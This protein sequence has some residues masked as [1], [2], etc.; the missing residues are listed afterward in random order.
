VNP[1]DSLVMPISKP[2]LAQVA[3][4]ET[5][6]LRGLTTLA[7]S[8]V[9]VA[10]LY[11]GREV[12]IP[13]TLAILLSFVLAPLVEL[14]RRIHLGRIP[15][16]VLAVFIAVSV[17]LAVG[18]IIGIQMAGIADDVPKYE[19]TIRGKI[20]AAKNLTVEPLGR[21]IG[22]VGRE[23][24]RA[25]Q[26]VQPAPTT[27]S[28]RESAP[29]PV[30]VRQP[31]PSPL[32]VAE[33]I[34]TPTLSPLATAAII[35]V[36]AIFVL[37]QQE[38]LRDRLIR[39]FGSR[40]LHRTTSAMDDAARRLS[41]YFLTQLAINAAFGVIIGIGLFFIGIPS[42]VL[43][44]VLAA[45]LRF[46]PYVGAPL[47]GILPVA[48]GAAVDPG[49]FMAVAA[50][51]LFLIA[52]PVMGQVVEPLLYGHSTG[53]SPV[54]VVVATIFWAWLWGP[55]GL[56]LATPLT[57]CLVVLGR[58]IER[59]EFLDVILGDR[60]ALTPIENFYQRILSGDPMEALEQAELLLKERS[61]SS[62]YDEI[63]LKGLQLA[64][65]DVLRG[66]I[67]GAQMARMQDAVYELIE[68]LEVHPDADPDSTETENDV[69]MASGAEQRLPRQPAPDVP[70]LP[71]EARPPAWRSPTAIMCVGGRRALDEGVAA[72]LAQLL[73]KHGLGAHAIAREELSRRRITSFDGRGALIVCISYLDIEGVPFQLRYMVR[74]I[75]SRLPAALIVA[76]YWGVDDPAIDDEQQRKSGG[77]DH[78]VRSLRE[79]VTTCLEVAQN[80]ALTG[81]EPE[82]PP[83]EDFEPKLVTEAP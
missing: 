47:A 68:G 67:T 18:S 83:A 20:T 61:L 79:A 22:S 75:R 7:V 19:A 27:T 70:L 59:L 57:L 28:G 56:I 78:Y 4:A 15:A 69:V 50:A 77:A 76:G 81:A 11:L 39:L 41:R 6:G 73:Q 40:D 30:E 32:A 3:P 66:V 45:L 38:D 82:H 42:P 25:E 34:I 5:P 53:L 24:D 46:V 26:N 49:W 52:E 23:V 62:Y 1:R 35:L 72:M 16:V 71:E 37:L 80:A 64:S 54:S 31:P 2:R 60:P 44:G 51:A 48:L 13:I 14:F 12:L 43:W 9:I 74:R 33:R 21:L 55:I 8:V 29:L 17:I 10:G 58:H 63:A 36:V 65:A